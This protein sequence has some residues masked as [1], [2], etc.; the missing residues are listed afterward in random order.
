MGKT[1]W[2]ILIVDDHPLFRE[3]LKTILK[4]DKRFSVEGEAGSYEEG[5]L[6]AGELN[7]NLVFVDIALPDRS[8]IRLTRDI[9]RLLPDSKVLV[10]SMHTK[11]NYVTE[12]FAAGASGYLAKD[13]ASDQL[14]QGLE[15]IIKGKSFLDNT[16][17]SEV[18]LKLDILSRKKNIADGSYAS[19]TNR[20]QEV[21]RLLVSKKAIPHIAEKLSLSPKTVENHRS[22]IYRKLG[23]KGKIE[24]YRYAVQIGLISADNW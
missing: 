6:K 19:L 17:S 2:K 18:A 21:L 16:L 11:Y 8:G 7:P 14:L 4:R 5:L 9:K 20:E 13:S 1:K 15:S 22:N 23:I 3:G 24:L 12:A 10:I